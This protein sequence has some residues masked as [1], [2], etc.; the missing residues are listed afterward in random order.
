MLRSEALEQGYEP[1]DNLEVF[2]IVD[3]VARLSGMTCA[4]SWDPW[5]E[6]GPCAV[7]WDGSGDDV[8]ISA[9]EEQALITS[10]EHRTPRAPTHVRSLDEMLKEIRQWRRSKI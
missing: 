1:D 8:A 6:D 3:E 2:D 9:D 7:V 5:G 4:I 10:R